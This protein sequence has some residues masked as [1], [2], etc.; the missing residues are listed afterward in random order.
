M[1]W[2]DRGSRVGRPV[3]SV[4][5]RVGALVSGADRGAGA[6]VF[7]PDTYANLS[8]KEA[9]VLLLCTPAGFERYFDRLAAEYAGLEPPEPSGPIP[10]ARVVGR[11][12]SPTPARGAAADAGREDSAMTAQ[13]G[14]IDAAFGGSRRTIDCARGEALHAAE[15]APTRN[16]AS[17]AP[18]CA[19]VVPSPTRLHVPALGAASTAP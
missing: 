2:L 7:T 11:E 1:D 17:R 9:R 13:T 16:A 4:G 10:E 6:G 14:R 12:E 3:E 15:V 5:A 18:S 8:G 19:T